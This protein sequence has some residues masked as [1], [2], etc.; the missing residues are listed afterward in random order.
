M[1]VRVEA[2]TVWELSEGGRMDALNTA[3]QLAELRQRVSHLLDRVA[4]NS[5]LTTA[6]LGLLDP[7]A[8]PSGYALQLALGPLDALIASMRLARDHKYRL[9]LRMVQRLHQA[10]RVWP[11]GESL[12]AKLAWGP[13]TPTDRTAVLADVTSGY[14]AGVF[15]LE[16]SV[17]M[18]QDAGFPIEDV[19]AEIERIQKR[20]FDQ[21]AK[22]ADATGDND[23]VRNYLGLPEADPGVPPVPLLPAPG[24]TGA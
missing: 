18:L 14:A 3:P 10:G 9:L 22:L 11:E 7:S 12:P 2:G 5:R 16:T 4:E 13:H 20:A 8:V 15:S 6:G 17:R 23:A 1:P 24:V 19:S 21:A